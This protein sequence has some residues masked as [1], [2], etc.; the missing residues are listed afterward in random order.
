M[1]KGLI[2]LS[3]GKCGDCQGY[4]ALILTYDENGD[5]ESMGVSDCFDD[6][7]DALND[8]KSMCDEIQEAIKKSG[9]K[10]RLVK[11]EPMECSLQ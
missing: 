9:H 7:F 3:V 2:K 1:N 8:G 10:E 5:H 11:I 4:R 6:K